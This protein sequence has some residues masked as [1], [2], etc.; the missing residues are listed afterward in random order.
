MGFPDCLEVNTFLRLKKYVLSC[1]LIASLNPV[2]GLGVSLYFVFR[3]PLT[4]V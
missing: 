4:F 3:Y 2:T 1:A